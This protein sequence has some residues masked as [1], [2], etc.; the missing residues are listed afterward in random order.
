MS[1]TTP[2][3]VRAR[4]PGLGDGWARLDGP[5]GTQM[6]DVA[7]EAMDAFMRSGDNANHGG[8]FRAAQATDALIAAARDAVGRLL[9]GTP[10]GVAF[11]PSMTA[12]TMRLASA[13]GRALRPGDEIVCTRLDHDANVAPWLIAAERAGATV[14]FADPEPETLELPAAAVEA[15]LGER[16]RWVAVTAAS[17]AVGT[18]PDL[19]GIVAAAHAAGARVYVDAV[20]AAPHRRIEVEALGAD[21]LACSAYKWFGPH[22]GVL[23]GRPDLLAELRPDKLRP[24]LDDVPDRWELGTLPFEALAGVRAA[25][26]FLLALDRD[27]LRAHE[28]RLLALMLDGLRTIDGV[29]VHGSARDRA[30][31]VMFSV[32]G[33]TSLDVARALAGREVAVWHGNYYALELARHL[34]L[35]PDGAVRAG[36]VAYTDE[37]DVQRLLAAVAEL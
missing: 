16:T 12:M 9:G 37:E 32:D 36:A 35:E 34:G 23:W 8:V 27:A 20:H 30:P 33:R 3:A 29:T 1:T 19:P 21:A 18:V 24:S 5:A 25:A 4:F 13:A 14:R 2:A 6:V 11:G 22:V 17:N 7:I 31:T 10:E 15:V 26:E 28:D